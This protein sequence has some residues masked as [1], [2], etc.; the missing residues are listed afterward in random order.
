MMK[1]FLIMAQRMHIPFPQHIAVIFPDHADLIEQSDPF[2]GQ[3]T[4]TLLPA[5]LPLCLDPLAKMTAI[6]ADISLGHHQIA[7]RVIVVFG[8]RIHLIP[9]CRQCLIELLKDLHAVAHL[10]LHR[11]ALHLYGI[12]HA[13]HAIVIDGQIHLILNGIDAR[14]AVKVVDDVKDDRNLMGRG[15]HCPAD[16]LLIHDR[17]DRRPQQDHAVQIIDMHPFIQHI[18]AIQQ[19]QMIAVICLEFPECLAGQRI[20][21]ICLIHM[22]IR[23]D[24][25]KPVR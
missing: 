2:S 6:L 8:L 4:I 5:D 22:K 19:L 25:G 12:F 11:K 1:S 18:D 21:R 17:R 16:L 24:A 13:H 15:G 9:R 23:I 14:Q 20:V 3:R 7:M 10:I